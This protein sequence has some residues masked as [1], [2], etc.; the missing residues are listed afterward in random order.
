MHFLQLSK[1]RLLSVMTF[2]VIFFILLNCFVRAEV[3]TLLPDE[4][5]VDLTSNAVAV[6]T[7]DTSGDSLYTFEQGEK[8]YPPDEGEST[9]EE[10]NNP[11]ILS[12][13]A[14][15]SSEGITLKDLA[16][17]V[18]YIVLALIAFLVFVKLYLRANNL[19][20]KGSNKFLDFIAS[21]IQCNLTGISSASSMKLRQ[22]LMLIPGQNLYLIEVDGKNLLIGGTHEGGVQFL[23]NVTDQPLAQNGVTLPVIAEP[24]S[25]FNLN[26]ILKDEELLNKQKYNDLFSN[27]Y[28]ESPFL[29]S[30]E[31][32]SN[33]QGKVK[34]DFNKKPFKRRTNFRQSLLSHSGQ[35]LK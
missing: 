21:K 26:E 7:N 5:N 6:E 12:N 25:N 2:L 22:T 27:S 35:G 31:P 16:L 32:Q 34:S 4:K 19:H 30:K 15:S 9:V 29:S 24:N 13:S 17:R 20:L 23:A 11:L 1:S 3:D 18:F 10:N 8:E 14:F 33:L 28:T